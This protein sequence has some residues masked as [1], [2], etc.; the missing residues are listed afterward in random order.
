MKVDFI[1]RLAGAGL[2]HVEATAFVSPKW[3]PQMAD[4]R[5]VLSRVSN[6]P[7]AG[8]T[9]PVL[10]PN[11]QG[12]RAAVEC[13]A[14]EV[15]IFGA[16]SESF[17]KKNINCSIAESL[18]R[19]QPVVE[20]ARLDGVAVRGYVSCVVGCPYEGRI[21][22]SQVAKVC[23]TLYDMG[24]YEISLGDTIGV[25]TPGSVGEMLKVRMEDGGWFFK[26]NLSSQEVTRLVPVDCLALHC[27][28][29]Y[30]QVSQSPPSL[31]SLLSDCPGPGQ[32][33]DWSP[34]RRGGG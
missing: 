3:V 24:C 33:P 21:E 14:R 32:H 27:H 13:G 11:L 12:Y 23:K 25:G 22:P 2:T 1:S 17:S 19:F 16:A 18:A 8:V 10:T 29:T 6:S 5:E 15:A 31:S 9:Y 26:T 30:G 7:E 28:D 20:A 34:A 4:H